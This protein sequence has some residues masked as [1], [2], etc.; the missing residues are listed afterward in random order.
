MQIVTNNSG[1]EI[2]KSPSFKC[3]IPQGEAN[4]CIGMQLCWYIIRNYV[5]SLR[6]KLKISATVTA[7][8]SYT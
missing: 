8:I 2:L 5:N 7:S 3:S 1:E 6:Y 4:I